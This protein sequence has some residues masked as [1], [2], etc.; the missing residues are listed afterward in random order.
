MHI[1]N[2]DSSSRQKALKQLINS[3]EARKLDHSKS[4]KNRKSYVWLC[5][6]PLRVRLKK[7]FR[8]WNGV[9]FAT[10]VFAAEK[11]IRYQCSQQIQLRALQV[12]ESVNWHGC[13][14]GM[15]YELWSDH[16]IWLDRGWLI[17]WSWILKVQGSP[18][19]PDN[20]GVQRGRN[21]SKLFLKECKQ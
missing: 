4:M 20:F 18:Q 5:F 21:L 12:W 3:V 16:G 2:H 13:G 17:D 1:N 6:S 7:H 9:W 14:Q 11:D 10:V 19:K 8:C 15:N